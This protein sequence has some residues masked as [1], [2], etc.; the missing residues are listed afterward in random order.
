LENR[1]K[2]VTKK[3]SDQK[4]L[5]ERKKKILA[6]IYDKK[7]HYPMKA[8]HIVAFGNDMAKFHLKTR[9]ITNHENRFTIT[10]EAKSDKQITR[11]IKY[12]TDKYGNGIHVNIQKI[13]KK[14]EKG[15][16]YGDLNVTIL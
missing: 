9:S 15:P 7:V 5:F 10:L 4:A 11:F 14:T 12:L 13:S 3:I 1:K 8:M 16:Y 2:D 6:T